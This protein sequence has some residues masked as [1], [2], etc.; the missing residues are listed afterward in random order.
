MHA[1]KQAIALLK[2][3]CEKAGLT[4]QALYP[5]LLPVM[6]SRA[7]GVLYGAVNDLQIMT[8]DTKHASCLSAVSAAIHTHFLRLE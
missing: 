2:S 4:P 5:T 7:Y 1:K 6:T 8:T 3:F